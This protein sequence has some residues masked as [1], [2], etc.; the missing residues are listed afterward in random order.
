MINIVVYAW[1]SFLYGFL[2]R[3]PDFDFSEIPQQINFESH[4]DKE[5]DVHWLEVPELPEFYVTG[6]TAE[7]LAEHFTETLL[8]YFDVPVY[9]AR[10]YKPGI[11]FD[12]NNQKT[13]EREII[14]LKEELHRALA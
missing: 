14:E 3:R 6:K 1:Q 12:F 2:K 9:F 13:K 5:N 8:V 10:R 4:Y 7:E 11:R